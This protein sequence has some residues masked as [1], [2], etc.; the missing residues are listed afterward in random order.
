MTAIR[1]SRTHR[2][3]CVLAVVA[4]VLPALAMLALAPTAVGAVGAQQPA[5]QNLTVSI[6]E[7]AFSAAD[8]MVSTGDTVTWVNEDRAPHDVTTTS[9]PDPFASGTL[10]QGQSYSYTFAAPGSYSYQCTI[11]PDMTASVTAMDHTAAP[12]AAPEPA[13][14]EVVPPAPEIPAESAPV[15]G[16]PA[17]GVPAAAPGVPAGPAAAV[18]AP[19][20]TQ[21]AP[22]TTQVVGAAQQ[23][24]Q[25]DPM[26]L[27]AGVALGVATLCLLLISPRSTNR[28]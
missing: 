10:K 19:A 1:P 21:P 12:A 3:R 4:V 25:L 2:F 15:A 16:A 23:G 22:G 20:G 24:R 26:L 5:P 7:F 17:D 6:R 13:P 18:P 27:V 14:A 9:A 28:R 8:L 11:H